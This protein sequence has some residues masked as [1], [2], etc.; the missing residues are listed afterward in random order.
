MKGIMKPKFDMNRVVF[1]WN[2]GSDLLE[3]HKCLA[4]VMYDIGKGQYINLIENRQESG[5]Y[6]AEDIERAFNQL[7]KKYPTEEKLMQY[8]QENFSGWK[9]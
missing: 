2:Y 1:A 7:I 9:G 5:L 8:W 3:F 6:R 4:F